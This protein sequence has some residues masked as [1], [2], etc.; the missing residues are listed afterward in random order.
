[1]VNSPNTTIEQAINRLFHKFGQRAS[2]QCVSDTHGFDFKIGDR[3][4]TASF[5][6]GSLNFVS[7]SGDTNFETRNW[8]KGI[9]QG[10]VREDS[11]KLVYAKDS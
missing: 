4:F 3:C 1:M 6:N 5:S 2:V 7:G 10:K 9:L 8:I 11:G